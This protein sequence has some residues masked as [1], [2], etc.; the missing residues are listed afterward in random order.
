MSCSK[1]QPFKSSLDSKGDPMRESFTAKCMMHASYLPSASCTADYV[2][3]IFTR[4]DIADDDCK[5]EKV[6][7]FAYRKL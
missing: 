4:D 5:F 6:L 7:V 3:P 1:L 2:C